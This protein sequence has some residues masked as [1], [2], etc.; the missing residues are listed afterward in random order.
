MCH[1][2]STDQ[3]QVNAP[4]LTQINANLPSINPIRD[5]RHVTPRGGQPISVEI[6]RRMARR[7]ETDVKT[8][9]L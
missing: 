4:N 2:L 7:E 8:R 6:R 1:F 3:R 5:R 9:C